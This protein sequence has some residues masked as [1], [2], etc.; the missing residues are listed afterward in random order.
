MSEVIDQSH[1]IVDGHVGPSYSSYVAVFVALCVFTAISF[2]VNFTFGIGSHL[3]MYII[4]TVAV[5]KA[6]LVCMFF[7]HLKYEWSKLYFLIVP[8]A[9][10]G[11]MMMIVL[12]PDIV[13]SKSAHPF[14]D[15][16]HSA[17]R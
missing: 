1:D 5:C 15:P 8:V 12:L 16:A 6:T 10:L 9:I 11:V 2:L 13:F 14:P 3:G 7:M 17:G 4:M